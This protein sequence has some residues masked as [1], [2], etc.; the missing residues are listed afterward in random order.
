MIQPLDD[1]VLLRMPPRERKTAR[2]V[3]I[4]AVAKAQPNQVARVLAVGPG[5]VRKGQR[6][7]VA[8]QPG[9][10]VLAANMGTH[11]QE[12]GESLRLVREHAILCKVR[13]D[14]D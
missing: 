5:A 11:V 8:V 13:K 3:I 7:P 4:P 10:Y 14:G 6:V 9:D 2:G 1:Y 12:A